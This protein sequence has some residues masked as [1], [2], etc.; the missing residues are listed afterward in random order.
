M[1]YIYAHNLAKDELVA[2]NGL[3]LEEIFEKNHK[4]FSYET[5]VFGMQ[6][7][8]KYFQTTEKL[9]Y[10]EFDIDDGITASMK[11]LAHLLY[12]LI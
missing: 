1:K 3:T 10:L 8:K 11:I 5:K 7:I 6:Y 12:D 9:D 4:Y 2:A